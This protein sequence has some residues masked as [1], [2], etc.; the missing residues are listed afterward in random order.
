MLSFRNQEW[1]S[2]Q[3]VPAN[4]GPHKTIYKRFVRWSR[5]GIFNQV[6]VALAGKKRT[7]GDDQCYAP[8]GSS[9]S[10]SAVRK[11][12]F[13]GRTGNTEHCLST[14]LSS[15][16][17]NRSRPFRHMDANCRLT[18]LT[19]GS[20]LAT[21]PPRSKRRINDAG[22][23]FI[24]SRRRRMVRRRDVSG[25]RVLPPCPRCQH[26]TRSSR[27]RIAVRLWLRRRLRPEY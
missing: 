11:G 14:K 1:A 16:H 21:L 26:A 2:W 7:P 19:E 3:D 18:I 5:L 10:R 24:Q 23:S 17:Y 13:P 6:F 25:A 9:H 4:Y 27:P 12:G 8:Q 20:S 22:G 15:K